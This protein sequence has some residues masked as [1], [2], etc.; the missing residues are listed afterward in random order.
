MALVHTQAA[1]ELGIRDGGRGVR[2][3]AKLLISWG[4]RRHQH[5]DHRY[6]ATGH[7]RCK[8]SCSRS[9]RWS[10]N[11]GRRSAMPARCSD[12]ANPGSVPHGANGVLCS[13]HDVVSATSLAVLSLQCGVLQSCLDGDDRGRSAS[14]LGSA[15][16]DWPAVPCGCRLE[17]Q[18][19]GR[20]GAIGTGDARHRGLF[21]SRY[22]GD[23]PHRRAH[24]G[25][26]PRDG[27]NHAVTTA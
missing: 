25:R 17:S 27:E 9:C 13:G 1:A 15:N 18:R 24:R 4:R 6:S 12:I 19:D 16:I 22:A 5:G 8:E 20:E 26:P 10:R 21:R 11:V 23:G 2:G 7:H 3:S 14:H